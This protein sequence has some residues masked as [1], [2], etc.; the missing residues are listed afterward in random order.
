[1][2]CPLHVVVYYWAD[3]QLVHGFC[4]YDNIH[5]HVPDVDVVLVWLA[6]VRLVVLQ[7]PGLLVGCTVNQLVADA[8][9]D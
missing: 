1:M 5:V 7:R 3:L 8:E 2:E 9:R 4:C 6:R